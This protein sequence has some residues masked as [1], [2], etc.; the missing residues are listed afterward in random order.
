MKEMWDERYRSS[1]YQYGTEPNTFFRENLE[2]LKPGSLLLPAEGEG[3]NAVYAAKLGW[4]VLAFDLSSEGKKK[5]ERL[6]AENGVS[7]QYDLASYEDFTNHGKLFDA[8][9]LFFTH[10][11]SVIRRPFHQR[12]VQ[13]LAPG[14]V[15]ILEG[16]HKDQLRYKTGGPSNPD[17]LFDEE[18]LKKDFSGLHI[19]KLERVERELSEGRLHLGPSAVVQLVARNTMN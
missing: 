12:L 1:E 11:A 3:R 17:F 9:G 6:A 14:G 5:A 15:L 19:D 7:F 8:I 4:E 13:I 18:S 16:F 2:N 10:Q